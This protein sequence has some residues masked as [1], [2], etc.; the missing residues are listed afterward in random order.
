MKDTHAM[1][2]DATC[3]ESYIRYPTDVKLLWESCEGTYEQMKRINRDIRLKN[4]FESDQKNLVRLFC[5]YKKS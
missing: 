5:F 1:F 3:Y 2:T 4:N